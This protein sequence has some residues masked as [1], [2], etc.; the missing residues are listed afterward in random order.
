VLRLGLSEVQAEALRGLVRDEHRRLEA[1]RQALAECRRELDRA[2]SRPL[3][4]SATVLELTIE[5]RVLEARER[6][7]ASDLEGALVGLLRPEQ[8]RR[9]QGLAPAAF[10]DMLVRLSA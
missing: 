3:P 9:L 10:G 1:A 5:E 4:D 7:L 8:A 6:E 2:L